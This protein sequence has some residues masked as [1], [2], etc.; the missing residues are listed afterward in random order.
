MLNETSDMAFKAYLT[1]K[2]QGWLLCWGRD[3]PAA[4]PPLPAPAQGSP[5]LQRRRVHRRC[6]CRM[7]TRTGGGLGGGGAV[8]GLT[9]THWHDIA[10][11][12]SGSGSVRRKGRAGPCR[13]GRQITVADFE[14]A[15]LDAAKSDFGSALPSAFLEV[16]IHTLKIMYDIILV[17]SDIIEL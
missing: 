17:C 6:K 1:S 5:A 7:T 4:P 8:G 9:G 16:G 15:E 13:G 3:E 12:L 2:I 11:C 10:H 14:L